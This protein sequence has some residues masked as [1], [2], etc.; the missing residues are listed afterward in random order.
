MNRDVGGVSQQVH[1][2]DLE[3]LDRQVRPRAEIGEQIVGG[4]RAQEVEAVV[5][6]QSRFL[7]AR[8]GRG[9]ED[10]DRADDD[11]VRDQEFA[12][13][14]A[15]VGERVQQRDADDDEQVRQVAD[16]DG[17]GAVAQDPEDRE[18]A[19]REARARSARC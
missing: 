17:F 6:D 10:R 18:Q 15:A 13:R 11:D 5:A 3:S 1:I 14:D 4:V 16:E 12:Q 19:Q 8:E 7:A 2:A 9:L